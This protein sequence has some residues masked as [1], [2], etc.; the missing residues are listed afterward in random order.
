[1]R[2]TIR[3]DI[4]KD[5]SARNPSWLEAVDGLEEAMRRIEEL[6]ANDPCSDFYLY[7]NQ[8]DKQLIRRLRRTLPRPN[9]MPRDASQKKT[10]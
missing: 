9:D 5:D 8:A 10:G 3:Y 1:M 2:D 7:C 4:F 6:A